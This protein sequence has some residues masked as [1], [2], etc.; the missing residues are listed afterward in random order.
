MERLEHLL[1]ILFVLIC[2]QLG[3]NLALLARA[4]MEWSR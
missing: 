2:L 4:Y 1:R 3:I